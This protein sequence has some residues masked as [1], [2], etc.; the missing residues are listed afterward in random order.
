MRAENMA[1]KTDAR[2]NQSKIQSFERT[3]QSLNDRIEDLMNENKNMN[4]A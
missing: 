2:S 3:I 1:L 4:D